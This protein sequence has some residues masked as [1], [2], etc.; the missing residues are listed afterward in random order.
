MGIG[1][2]GGPSVLWGVFGGGDS[3]CLAA[4]A[5][6]NDKGSWEGK[7]S[8]ESRSFERLRAGPAVP[9]RS[10]AAID[11]Q[12]DAEQS[13]WIIG[14]RITTAGSCCLKPALRFQVRRTGNIGAVRESWRVLLD[15]STKVPL[16]M[17]SWPGPVPVK[18]V[19]VP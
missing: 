12:S 1:L 18:S 15:G 4:L 7:V 8:Q 3:S 13:Y 17:Y 9:L 6:R 14:S 16:M 11:G 2:A 19:G 10:P 5:R